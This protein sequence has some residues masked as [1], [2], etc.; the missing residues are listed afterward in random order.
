M[1]APRHGLAISVLEL[2]NVD[3]IAGPVSTIEQGFELQ[4]RHFASSEA[5]TSTVAAKTGAERTRPIEQKI[6][7]H[8]LIRDVIG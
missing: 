4:M 2:T 6:P 7:L 1:L 8:A 5:E 3:N